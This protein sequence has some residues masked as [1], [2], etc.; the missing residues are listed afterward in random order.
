M[1]DNAY[2][3]KAG[4]AVQERIARIQSPEEQTAAAEALI[5]S[6]DR[7]QILLAINL[8]DLVKRPHHL[9]QALVENAPATIE[10]VLSYFKFNPFSER[11]RQCAEVLGEIAFEAGE[12]RDQRIIAALIEAL[13][14]AVQS[15]REMPPNRKHRMSRSRQAERARLGTD[16]A[17]GPVAALLAAARGFPVPEAT[18]LMF[19]VLQAAVTERNFSRITVRNALKFLKIRLGEDLHDSLKAQFSTLDENSPLREILADY[20]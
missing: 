16:A 15:A 13:K 12:N 6:G 11:G 3:G 5:S 2:R 4:L 8:L 19:G 20:L 14:K 7:D 18:E 17:S 9:V 10:P 1:T